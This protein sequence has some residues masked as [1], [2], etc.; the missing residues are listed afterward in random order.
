MTVLWQFIEVAA[1]VFEFFVTINLLNNVMN[2][3]YSGNKKQL[4]NVIFIVLL[5]LYISVINRIYVFEG[6]L[7]LITI[8]ITVIYTFI[9]LNGS[10]VLKIVM[11]ILSFSIMLLINASVTYALSII[12]GMPSSFIFS[13]NDSIRLLAIF[14]TKFL[15][16]IAAKLLEHLFTKK[17]L[18]LKS[19][20]S[21]ISF[22]MSFLTFFIAVALVKLQIDT[23]SKNM[24]FGMC[25]LSL[26]IMNVFIIYMMKKISK[27][28]KNKLKISLLEL[29]L[30]EQKTMIEDAG[31]ISYE[32]KKVEHDLKHHILCV[33]GNIENGDTGAARSYLKNLLH[34]Y[35]TS[36][37]KYIC[38][39]NSA[40]N[41]I[42]NLKISRCHANNID[43]KVEVESDFSHF[44]DID[45]CVLIANL[46]DNAIEASYNVE[47]PQIAVTIKNEKNYLCIIVKNRI[48]SSVLDKNERLKTTKADK[49][50]H[51]LGLYSIS[52]IVEKYDGIKS[53]YEKNGYFIA[54]VWLKR[55]TFSLTERIKS[56]ENYQTRHN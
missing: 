38:I 45:L 54:D 31:H 46:L 14:I 49:S 52:Q 53:Y 47:M 22:V 5:T 7:S 3:K 16:F 34:E 6:W 4:L 44:N 25:V 17:A 27:E 32:I 55:D 29:Q 51:G 20:G 42:L 26:M 12:F 21:W 13:E 24:L 36:I 41:S 50:K 30:S 18:D 35:E 56:A 2:C 8:I 9:A 10:V 28:N 40:I 23:H 15:Y 48:D 43:I 1:T 19:R 37:F 33:L 11:P 39:D